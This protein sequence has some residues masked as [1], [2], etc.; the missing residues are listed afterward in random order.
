MAESIEIS[1]VLPATARQVYEAWLDSAEHSAF[2]G[3]E[4]T[5]EPRVGGAFNAGSG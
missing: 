1:A 3:D 4:A 2:T 5:I